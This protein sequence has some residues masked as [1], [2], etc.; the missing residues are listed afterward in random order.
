MDRLLRYF[1]NSD[2]YRGAAA[3]V[4]A[5]YWAT[6]GVG[7]RLEGREAADRYAQLAASAA[8]FAPREII[9]TAADV[10]ERLSANL[11]TEP[12]MS[13]A[14]PEVAQF[15]QLEEGEVKKIVAQAEAAEK[16]RRQ[17]LRRSLEEQ[18]E[19]LTRWLQN[20]LDHPVEVEALE[21]WEELASI[22]R[23]GEKAEAW[24][25]KAQALAIQGLMR[26]RGRQAATAAANARLLREAVV[27]MDRR[28]TQLQRELD[29]QPTHDL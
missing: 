19:A 13:A 18:R 15:L 23:L 7:S 1:E 25:A 14:A 29:A 16:E 5:W 24:M 17:L 27:D 11:E 20:H 8:S 9:P 3:S 10:V 28:A 22:Q 6:R 21:P 2:F 26:G 4:L 12:S